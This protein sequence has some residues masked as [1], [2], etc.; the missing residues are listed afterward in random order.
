MSDKPEEKGTVTMEIIA[1]ARTKKAI[2]TTTRF[3][4]NET[5]VIRWKY[6]NKSGNEPIHAA[7]EMEMPLAI[8]V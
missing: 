6:H 4:R 1:I 5:D 7:R 2:G 8:H 3:A